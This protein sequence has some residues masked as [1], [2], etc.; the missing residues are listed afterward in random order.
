MSIDDPT[1]LM[2]IYGI[3]ILFICVANVGRSQMASSFLASMQIG[4]IGVDSAGTRVDAPGETLADYRE[5]NPNSCFVIDAMSAVGFDVSLSRRTLLT[6]KMAEKFDLLV[7]MAESDTEPAWLRHSPKRVRW[8]VEDPGGRSL[9]ET[10]AAR[11]QI[12]LKVWQ[13][14]REVYRLKSD[15]S[16]VA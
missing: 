8:P 14:V 15:V 5:R 6:E 3:R 16:L 7:S 13:F 4:G 1:V 11:D 2:Y 10:I 12:E 9:V